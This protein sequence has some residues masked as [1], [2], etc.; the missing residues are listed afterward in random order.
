M[1]DHLG[2]RLQTLLYEYSYL[3]DSGN[4]ML[5]SNTNTAGIMAGFSIVLAVVLYGKR[6]YNKNLVI[7]FGIYNIIALILFG[8][9]SA[10]V[11]AIAI[12][13]LVIAEKKLLR[14]RK[15]NTHCRNFGHVYCYVITGVSCS[16]SQPKYRDVILY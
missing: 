4:A 11:A 9:R 16:I 3:K 13:I 2:I 8:C 10:D 14:I 6:N 1:Y 12:V 7:A 5:F 15:R